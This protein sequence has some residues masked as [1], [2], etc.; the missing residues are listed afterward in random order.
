M[1]G[2][3]SAQATRPLLPASLRDARNR[4]LSGPLHGHLRHGPRRCPGSA[5]LS[6]P[7]VTVPSVRSAAS[8]DPGSAASGPP[9]C[10]LTVLLPRDPVSAPQPPCC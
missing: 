9:D 4:P 8:R 7:C 2:R 3:G 5:V 10:V 6:G 1:E